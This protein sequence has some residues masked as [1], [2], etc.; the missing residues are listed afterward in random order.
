MNELDNTGKAAEIQATLDKLNKNDKPDKEPGKRRDIIKNVL[1]IFLAA[2]L[3]LTF[4]SNTIR[5]RSLAE[6]ST[7]RST[8]G[9]LT[10]RVRGSGLVESNQ[11]YDVT[12]D[13]NKTVDTIMVKTGQE[14]KKDDVLFTVGSEESEELSAAEDALAALELEYQ[15]AILAPPDDYTKENQAISNA[16]ADLAEAIRKR[17]NAVNNQGSIQAAKDNYSFN[18]S[19]L[20]YY[21]KLQN[22]LQATV[23]AIDSDEYSMGAAEYTGDLIV[24]K[25][26][27]SNAETEYNSAL[28]LYS[29]LLSGSEEEGGASQA[30]IDAAKADCDAKAAA[31]DEAKTAYDNA[32]YSLREDLVGQLTDAENNVDYYTMLTSE[33]ENSLSDSSLSMSIDDLNS[34]VQAKQRA[35]EDLITDLNKTKSD[36]NNKNQLNSLDL[37][38][39][40]AEIEKAKKKVDKLKEKSSITEIKSKYNG[41]ISSVNIQAGDTTVPDMPCI[42]VDISEE[43]YTAKITVEGDKTKKL[44]KGTAAEVVNNWSGNVQAVLTDI[45][46]DSSAGSKNRVLVFS[47]TGD[48]DSGSYIDLSIPCST[49]NY[50]V[51]VPKSAVYEDSN[52]KFVLTVTS[53]SSPLGNRYYAQRVDVE[54]L[55]SDESSCAVSGNI[56]SGEY[57]ITAASLPVK[58]G[59]QVRM[60]E[61]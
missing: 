2:L 55:S 21:T 38:A 6:I 4:F 43:G 40:K 15:K 33:Y 31:R 61:K 44:K 50:D 5:N 36:N 1:I 46:N 23:T 8:S 52:G 54:V 27:Y 16:R 18:K 10:E 14:I 26:N 34:D 53:K 17:D 9:K 12:V 60:N 59:D 24:L 49:A 35:L 7:E 3:V 19:Q 48:I 32:K 30:D 41:V 22:K 47:I 25:N 29:S 51:I 13:G 39:K 20:N 45:K 57:V 11:S 56:S 28:S 37:D 58:P 42:T